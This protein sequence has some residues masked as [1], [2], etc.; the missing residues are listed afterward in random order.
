MKLKVGQQVE[1]W[2][3]SS[4]SNPGVILRLDELN[5]LRAQIRIFNK[6]EKVSGVTDGNQWANCSEEPKP[7]FFCLVH[8]AEKQAK[9]VSKSSKKGGK[10]DE[11][12]SPDSDNPK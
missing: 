1:M 9:K 4:V 12:D 5:P 2:F 11:K 6:G 7:G 10:K 8:Q 3:G